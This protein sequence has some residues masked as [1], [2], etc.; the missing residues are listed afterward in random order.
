MKKIYGSKNT[1]NGQREKTGF[2]KDD[3][4]VGVI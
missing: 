3:R 1:E 2:W 4:G